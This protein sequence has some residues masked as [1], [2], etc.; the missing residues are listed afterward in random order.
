[1]GHVEGIIAISLHLTSVMMHYKKSP[2]MLLPSGPAWFW[3]M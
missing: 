2:Q 3:D 1:M